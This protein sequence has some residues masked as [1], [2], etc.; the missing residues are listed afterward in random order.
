MPLLKCPE[1]SR[2]CSDSASSCPSCGHPFSNRGWLKWI[3]IGLTSFFVLIILGFTT[4]QFYGTDKLFGFLNGGMSDQQKAAVDDA[5]SDLL[6]LEAAMDVGVSK[7]TFHQSVTTAKASTKRATVALEGN[8]KYE[9]LKVLLNETMQIFED[10]NT[11]WQI[12]TVTGSI[13]NVEDTTYFFACLDLPEKKVTGNKS[14]D[15]LSDYANNILCDPDGSR[16]VKKYS[17]TMREY[18]SEN[19]AS[20]QGR[21]E[22]MEALNVMWKL[23]KSK[24][25]ELQT[26]RKDLEGH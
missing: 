20:K 12:K 10:A 17:L 26:Y 14:K 13:A 4:I 11:L 21:V 18:G 5:I 9:K 23:G 6:K 22:K 2:D 15:A 7:L 19:V 3:L 16:F 8:K 24:L 25:A 1:C